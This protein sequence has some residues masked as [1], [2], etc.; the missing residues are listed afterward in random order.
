M[1]MLQRCLQA[2][3]HIAIMLHPQKKITEWMWR[4]ATKWIPV[5]NLHWNNYFS[6]KSTCSLPST[7][8]HK[9]WVYLENDKISLGAEGSHYYN[10]FFWECIYSCWLRFLIFPSYCRIIVIW[11]DVH[12]LLTKPL[13]CAIYSPKI[14]IYSKI[15]DEN[16]SLITSYL[17]NMVHHAKLEEIFFLISVISIFSEIDF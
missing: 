8:H 16:Q 2:R 12:Y 14:A 10:I 5:E 1:C 9:W 11:S 6:M 13:S 3:A 17:S 4:F 15:Y 7:F